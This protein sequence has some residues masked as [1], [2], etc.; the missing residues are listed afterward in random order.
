MT[1]DPF[2]IEGP[3][4]ISFSG[5]RTSGYMLRRILDAVPRQE[6]AD[7]CRLA[8]FPDIR[9]RYLSQLMHAAWF[10]APIPARGMQCRFAIDVP[11]NYLPEW[12][13]AGVRDVR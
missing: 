7:L 11:E 2:L 9:R 8:C 5:G 10:P 13:L 1:R 6:W 4:V 3:A 12:A